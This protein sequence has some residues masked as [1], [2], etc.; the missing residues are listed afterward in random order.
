METNPEITR[1]K[2]VV[3]AAWTTPVIAAAIVAPAASASSLRTITLLGEPD[4]VAVGE[5]FA[6][7]TVE[8]RVDGTFVGLDEG[9]VFQ[10]LSGNATFGDGSAQFISTTFEE[11][12]ATAFGLIAGDTP[13]TISIMVSSGSATLTVSLTIIG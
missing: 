12:Q 7:I 10:I 11:G 3:A 13:G 6:P 1:R 9:V 8:V 5:E 4:P 2:V